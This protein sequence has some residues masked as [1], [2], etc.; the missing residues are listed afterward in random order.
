MRSRFL[1]FAITF[2]DN[3]YNNSMNKLFSEM[4]FS[5]VFKG[6]EVLFGLRSKLELIHCTA[7]S[8][9]HCKFQFV[10]KLFDNISKIFHFNS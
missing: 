5:L 3:I 1:N 6:F 10:H 2:G 4:F 7:L 9:I 8:Q